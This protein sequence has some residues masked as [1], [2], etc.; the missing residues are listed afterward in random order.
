METIK[1]FSKKNTVKMQEVFALITGFMTL[2]Y[3]VML[4][5]LDGFSVYMSD[6][7]MIEMELKMIGDGIPVFFTI[8]TIMSIAGIAGSI[9]SL[10]YGS[11]TSLKFVP[12][13][14]SF[15]GLIAAITTSD[16]LDVAKAVRECGSDP[17]SALDNIPE[18]LGGYLDTS[19]TETAW[20][21]GLVI[22]ISA[23]VMLIAGKIM[24]KHGKNLDEIAVI[25]AG[26]KQ[27]PE[28][29]AQDAETVAEAAGT[30]G[31][32]TTGVDPETAADLFAGGIGEADAEEGSAAAAGAVD[33]GS[34]AGT[35]DVMAVS[36]GDGA[37][38]NAKV[39]HFSRKKIAIIAAA[40]AV[41][42]GIFAAYELYF[43]YDE[44]D[45]SDYVTKPTFAGID[46]HGTVYDEPD[47][48]W[49]KVATSEYDTADSDSDEGMLM[50]LAGTDFEQLMGTADFKVSKRK[51]LSNGDVVTVT[52][53]YDKD[54]AKEMK[55]RVT[56]DTFK[57]KVKGLSE[58]YKDGS[59]I[60]SEAYSAIMNELSS[61]TE[62]PV[63]VYFGRAKDFENYDDSVFVIMEETSE[64]SD[65]PMYEIYQVSPAYKES[66]LENLGSEMADTDSEVS[67]PV[68][69]DT[70]DE[71]VDDLNRCDGEEFD[72]HK[73]DKSVWQ[74]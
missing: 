7:S 21:L 18:L 46:G 74:Q 45:I 56:G 16:E 17:V 23:I 12:M 70:Y 54:A 5:Q 11:R 69:Y 42:V 32:E 58:R 13:A 19:T 73:V 3:A 1:N 62:T 41:I 37:A 57:V 67:W 14:Q 36:S 53:K 29:A 68:E 43:S 59:D 20:M 49:D 9:T 26:Q 40:A 71:A 15:L 50:D 52:V 34:A 10:V 22:V 31:F 51:G 47:I 35:A 6:E 48:N 33:A 64:F 24:S 39:S 30:E 8:V 66:K 27:E 63:S 28:E 60:S 65:E 38:V 25:S 61:D 72:L 4:A 44:L 2:M 55:L